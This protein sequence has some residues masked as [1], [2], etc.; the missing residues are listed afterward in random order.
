VQ[1]PNCALVNYEKWN[2]Q[3]RTI[4]NKNNEDFTE[5]Q[6]KTNFLLIKNPDKQQ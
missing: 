6:G 5:F 4:N 1:K 3:D 2:K